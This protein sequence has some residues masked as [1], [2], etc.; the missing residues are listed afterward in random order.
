MS[1]M[2]TQ[3]HQYDPFL[4]RMVPSSLDLISSSNC[5]SLIRKTSACEQSVPYAY[6]LVGSPEPLS[7]AFAMNIYGLAKALELWGW[8]KTLGSA[9]PWGAAVCY[10]W[11]CFHQAGSCIVEICSIGTPVGCT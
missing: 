7:S 6:P 4:S 10:V 8:N 2:M 3:M 11:Q 1:L 5:I 9:K